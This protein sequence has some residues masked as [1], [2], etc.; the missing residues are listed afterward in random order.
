MRKLLLMSCVLMAGCSGP[1][2][3]LPGGQLSG[4]E[5]PLDLSVLPENVEVVQLETNPADPYSVNIGYQLID[6]QIYID[7]APERQWYQHIEANPNVRLRFEGSE[8]VHPAT[9][10]RVTDAR[11]LAKFDPERIVLRLSPRD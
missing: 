10:Q 3:W 9:A 1:F 7:P 5:T 11:V 6:G 8:V 2:M 4:K